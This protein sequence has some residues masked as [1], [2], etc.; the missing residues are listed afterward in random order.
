MSADLQIVIFS[1]SALF[2]IAAI[3][4]WFG[5]RRVLRKPAPTRGE[6]VLLLNK[7]VAIDALAI[8][9][10]ASEAW[11]VQLPLDNSSNTAFV[12]G[13]DD[14]WIVGHG[15]W[16]VEIRNRD[17][18]FGWDAAE[19]VGGRSRQAFDSH[20][21]HIAAAC[22]ASPAG[23]TQSAA[24]AVA[25]T[26][27]CA[28][29][30]RETVAVVLPAL[31]VIA[32]FGD[33]ELRR[34]IRND[35]VR[36]VSLSVS[37]STSVPDAQSAAAAA[38]TARERFPEFVRRFAKRSEGEDFLARSDRWITVSEATASGVR[39]DAEDGSTLE[40]PAAEITDWMIVS[41][42]AVDGGFAQRTALR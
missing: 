38:V 14:D 41:P 5:L 12:A 31:G 42:T 24:T 25:A 27:A 7:P 35:P 2:L 21:A 3:A 16:Q 1:V 13:S 15:G 34:L 22:I 30:Q 23:E 26:L 39:G 6:I 40:V 33:D 4:L 29:D 36:F 11:G 28:L 19:S 32:P 18:A 8:Q 20:T 37:R 9:S 10:A 17:H